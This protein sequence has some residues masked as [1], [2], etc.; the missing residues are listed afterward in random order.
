ME[1]STSFLVHC[2]SRDLGRSGP[3]HLLNGAAGCIE[4]QTRCGRMNGERCGRKCSWL[5]CGQHREMLVARPNDRNGRS[6]LSLNI[7]QGRSSLSYGYREIAPSTHPPRATLAN[8]C[9]CIYCPT[10]APEGYRELFLHPSTKS[11]TR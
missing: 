7:V 9:G 8:G 4:S 5:I 11:D 6:C 10:S 3:D 1:T 2:P